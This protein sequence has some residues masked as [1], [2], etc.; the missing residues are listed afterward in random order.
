MICWGTYFTPLLC[1][2][3]R[4][5]SNNETFLFRHLILTVTIDE[6]W[7]IFNDLGD[8]VVANVASFEAKAEECTSVSTRLSLCLSLFTA[9][10]QRDG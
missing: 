3:L 6:Q 9:N 4:G 1:A 8:Y 10:Y 2:I 7:S 5:M